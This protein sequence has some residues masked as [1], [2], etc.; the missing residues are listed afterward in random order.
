MTVNGLRFERC[1]KS[2]LLDEAQEEAAMVADFL[3]LRE[4]RTMPVSGGFLD[5]PPIYI[6]TVRLI[7]DEI[8]RLRAEA[9]T[10]D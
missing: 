6:E 4:H 1:P 10:A 8:E 2:W 7:E 9:G 3:W 5:Q